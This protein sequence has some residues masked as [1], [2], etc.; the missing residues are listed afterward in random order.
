VRDALAVG[1]FRVK[2][3]RSPAATESLFSCVAKR[4]V[5]KREGHPAWRLPPIHGRQVREPGPGFSTGHPALAKRHRHPCRCPLRGLSSPAH[6]R[7]GAP[8]KQRA[9]LARTVRKATSRA[10]PSVLTNSFPCEAGGG[11]RRTGGSAF[12]L[13]FHRVHAGCAPLLTGPLCGGETESTGRKAG[14]GRMPMPFRRYTE[15]PSKSPAPA[16]GLS[17]H[18]WAESAKRGV[19]FSWLL[20]WTSKREVTRAP[21]AHESFCFSR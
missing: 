10:T 2:S 14:I 15:V 17:A 4:K 6:R 1:E 18:G 8:V 20:F 21:Q 9:I 13:A 11:G 16:H 3:G 19:V 12:D 5:T 7:T